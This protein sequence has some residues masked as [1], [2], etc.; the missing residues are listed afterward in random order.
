MNEDAFTLTLTTAELLCAATALGIAALQLPPEANSQ[1]TGAALQAEIRQGYGSLQQRGLVEAVSPVQWQVDNLLTILVHW[2]AAPD[3]VL[4]LDAWQSTGERRQAFLFFWQ[5][6][7]LWLQSE[8][9]THH[10]TLFKAADSWLKHSTDWIGHLVEAVDEPVL[11][12]PPVNLS[13]FLPMVQQNVTVMELM[14]QRAGLAPEMARQTL[15]NLAVVERAVTLTWQ[16]GSRQISRQAIL[17]CAPIGTW[18][19]EVGGKDELVLLRPFSSPDLLH[20]LSADV[21]HFASHFKE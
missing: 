9:N 3:S 18:G 12:I 11:P 7:A 17:L 6:Q 4:K 1:P 21:I 15:A 10:F 16:D 5:A 2:L 13:A 14:M 20:L 8:T 19:G